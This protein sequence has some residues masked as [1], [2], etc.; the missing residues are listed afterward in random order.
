MLRNPNRTRSNCRASRRRALTAAPRQTGTPR[1]PNKMKQPRARGLQGGARDTASLA[2]NVRNGGRGA[3][4]P[5]FVLVAHGV[6]RTPLRT[7]RETLARPA[8]TGEISWQ[9]RQARGC[10]EDF[11]MQSEKPT[12][13]LAGAKDKFRKCYAFRQ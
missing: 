12:A 13:Q 3:S 10:S 2:R 6:G 8:A 5:I 4:S 1:R 7:G 11:S 9:A